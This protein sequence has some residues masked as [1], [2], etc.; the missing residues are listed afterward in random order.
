MTDWLNVIYDEQLVCILEVQLQQF[1]ITTYLKW[2][3]ARGG[4]E[5]T[6]LEAKGQGHKRKCS[7]KKSLQFFFQA[8]SKKNG[9]EKHFKPIYKILT[10]QKIRL[11]S[12]RGQGNF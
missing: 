6:R 2:P 12:S 7:L 3:T 9:L 1:A 11:S 10:I 5:D 8:I 4:V